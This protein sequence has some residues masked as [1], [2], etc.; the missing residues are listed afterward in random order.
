MLPSS[1]EESEL[2]PPKYLETNPLLTRSAT[3]DILFRLRSFFPP[4]HGKHGGG[5][6]GG[7][8]EV[9]NSSR[10]INWFCGGPRAGDEFPLR[11][12]A[13]DDARFEF[14][15]EASCTAEELRESNDG[16]LCGGGPSDTDDSRSS[17]TG[18][19]ALDDRDG[20]SSGAVFAL[21][22]RFL[23]LFSQSD[24]SDCCPSS[25]SSQLDLLAAT[26]LSVSCLE[27]LA[28]RPD[29][30]VDLTSLKRC[31]VVAFETICGLGDGD[32]FLDCDALS[33]VAPPNKRPRRG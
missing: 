19:A 31:K 33:G 13:N 15:V 26:E 21:V 6:Q 18:I 23:G 24:T 11:T 14:G 5:R 25:S 10:S 30:F 7:I 32:A 22:T 16:A 17:P 8:G 12:G 28:D 9:C 29:E 20:T 3:A 1:S 2:S 27:A 4:L